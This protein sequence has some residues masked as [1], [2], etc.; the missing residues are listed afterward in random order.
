MQN[1][2]G[3]I[4]SFGVSAD[5]MA[6]SH[7]L[8]D[9]VFLGRQPYLVSGSGHWGQTIGRRAYKHHCCI[10]PHANP[11]AWLCGVAQAEASQLGFVPIIE[12]LARRTV[13]MNQTA[14]R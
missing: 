10:H 7:R 6:R 14:A 1:A 4:A 9:A 13:E 12:A 8:L 2:K 3:E 5:P 11:I